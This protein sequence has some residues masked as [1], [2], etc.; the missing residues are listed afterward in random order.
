[1]PTYDYLCPENGKT[2]EISH[3]M[4]ET[5][6]TW[7]DLCERTGIELGDTPADSPI[8]KVIT[9]GAAIL[10]GSSRDSATMPEMSGGAC[11]NGGGCG[12]G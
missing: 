4:A 1:M 3:R 8:R 6:T 5:L 11:C 7:G 10:G 9:G 12:C 2:V